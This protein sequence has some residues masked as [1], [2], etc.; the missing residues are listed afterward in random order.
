MKRIFSLLIIMVTYVSCQAQPDNIPSKEI[1]IAGAIMAAPD[2]MREDAAVLGYNEK[3][4][5]VEL[6]SGTNELVCIADDPNREGFNTTCYHKNLE[7]YKTRGRELVAEGIGGQDWFDKLEQ[8][9]SDGQ[10]KM[11]KKA[12]TLHILTGTEFSEDLMAVVDA[13]YR[14]VIYISDATPASS[15]LPAKPRTPDEPWLMWP[16]T[17]QAHIMIKERL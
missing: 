11:P 6:R 16:G 12:S 14:Y 15:G 2:E 4:N 8:E 10:L 13:Y 1:Q 7:P 5:F 17:H 3:G 9:I